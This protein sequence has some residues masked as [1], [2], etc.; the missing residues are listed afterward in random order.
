MIIEE[1]CL[2]QIAIQP[3]F[4]RRRAVLRIGN[5]FVYR[6]KMEIEALASVNV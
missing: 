4:L 6:G 3:P 5:T 1:K 2:L